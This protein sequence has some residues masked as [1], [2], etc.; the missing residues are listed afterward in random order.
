MAVRSMKIEIAG[1]GRESGRREEWRQLCDDCRIMINRLWQIWLVHHSTRGSAGKLRRHFEAHKKWTIDK[2]GEKPAWPCNALEA[3]LTTTADPQ[4]FYRILSE[5]FP[6]VH[7]RTRGLLRNAWESS[8]RKRKAAS[9]SLPGWVA[10]LFG[11]E[12]LPSM[13]RPQPIPFDKENARLEKIDG[14]YWLEVRIQRL[15]PS[16]KSVVERC[17]L[18]ANKRK[19]RNVRAIME[20]ILS[21]EVAWKGSFIHYEQRCRKWFA[22]LSYERPEKTRPELNREKVL[23]VRP[24]RRSPWRLRADGSFPYGG[25]GAHVEHARRAILRERAQRK[26]HY[27]WAG[28]NQKGHGRKR[29]DSVWTKLSSRWRDFTKRYNNE[30]TR[31]IVLYAIKNGYGRIVYLQPKDA[32]RGSRYLS[33][34]GNS[35][36]S[37]MLWDYFQFGSMMA[38]KCQD[39]G[40]EYGAKTKQKPVRQKTSVVSNRMRRVR[41]AVPASTA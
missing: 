2:E 18:M 30:V 37:A 32:T 36:G 12:S 14:K 17:E 13:T 34:A 25:N 8:L 19:C 26:E 4:S 21:G 6:Q 16:G 35:D 23:Y 41:P 38:S 27:R 5:E 15:A 29:A 10:I 22:I 7:V 40:I 39:E 28:S 20:Q 11:L 1:F 9:G 31:R 24:G 3:P 33:I